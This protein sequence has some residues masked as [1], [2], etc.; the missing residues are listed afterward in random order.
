VLDGQ[1]PRHGPRIDPRSGMSD[2]SEDQNGH[3]IGRPSH[4]ERW[5]ATFRPTFRRKATANLRGQNVKKEVKI[6]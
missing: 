5:G 1:L 4:A 6:V 3:R 2:L